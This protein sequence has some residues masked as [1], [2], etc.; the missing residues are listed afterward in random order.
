MSEMAKAARAA[1]KNKA[2]RLGTTDPYQKVDAS[3]WSP[4]EPLNADAKTGLRPVSRRAYKKGGKVVGKVDGPKAKMH[5]GRKP[6]K[7]GGSTEAR[8]WINEK[9]NRNVKD[10]NEEREGE[11]HI[12]GLK[13]GGRAKKFRGGADTA[14]KTTTPEY[15][16]ELERRQSSPSSSA[17]QNAP[18]PPRRPSDLSKDEGMTAEEAQKFMDSRKRGGRTKKMDG[19]MMTATMAPGDPRLDIVKKRAMNFTNNPVVPGQKKGGR[20]ERHPDEAMDKAL[21]KKMVKKEARTGKVGG[22][23]LSDPNLMGGMSQMYQRRASGGK[24]LDGELQGTRP[25][26]GR[27]A[28]AEGGTLASRSRPATADTPLPTRQYSSDTRQYTPAENQQRAVARYQ[29]RLAQ[30][31]TRAGLARNSRKEGINAKLEEA[32][33]NNP[34]MDQKQISD[35]RRSLKREY[36]RGAPAPAA[37]A[38]ATKEVTP[39]KSPFEGS[40]GLGGFNPRDNVPATATDTRGGAPAAGTS[41]SSTGTVGGANVNTQPNTPVAPANPP[42]SPVTGGSLP[43][44]TGGPS[45]AAPLNASGSSLPFQ[46]QQR[47]IGQIDP[48]MERYFAADRAAQAQR[49]QYYQQMGMGGGYSMSPVMGGGYPLP[50]SF[51]Y[52]NDMLYPGQFPQTGGGYPFP[53]MA[54]A[55]QYGRQAQMQNAPGYGGTGIP[56]SGQQPELQAPSAAPAQPFKRGGRAK[57]KTNIN[58]VIAAGKG[59]QPQDG[60]MPP[61]PGGAMPPP[62]PPPPMGAGGPPGMPPG[63]AP[64]MP[65]GPPMGMPMGGPPGMPPMP[66]KSGG[67]A[68]YKDMTAGAGSGEGRLQKTEIQSNKRAYRKAGGG[69]YRSYADMDAGAGSGLGRLEKT[70][71]Q[72]RK[73]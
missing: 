55:N 56:P 68:S 28:K 53:P 29:D 62:P 18:L 36:K 40:V 17:P 59:G 1:M 70:E 38:V 22:G 31:S 25:T 24:A 43:P 2:K 21:I 11:K 15:R 16:K 61:P 58:I 54:Q 35:L 37:S 39:P 48:A 65:P 34:N 4:P 12:G 71:I 45:V 67:R 49:M 19:G 33:R 57:G 52:G 6:R 14:N 41:A 44:M 66:R 42:S 63:G 69:V 10:A 30:E 51:G 27:R 64:P 26:G 32:L 3:S 50:Q 20:V 23:V 13:A 72:A 5:A 9:I 8:S 73:R 60:M 7:S 46:L 47:Q